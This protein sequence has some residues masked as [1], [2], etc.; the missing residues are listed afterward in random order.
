MPIKFRCPKC[1]KVYSVKKEYTGKKAKCSCG[2]IIVIPR[3]R[4]RKAV[5][6]I[7]DEVHSQPPFFLV[8]RI[9]WT[10]TLE[11]S[12]Q[13]AMASES[14]VIL[15]RLSVATRVGEHQQLI[16]TNR[17][18]IELTV[19]ARRWGW[20]GMWDSLS[21][22]GEIPAIG[23]ILE[24]LLENL[25]DPIDRLFKR[26]YRHAYRF[27]AVANESILSVENLPKKIEK[28]IT[29]SAIPYTKIV[30]PSVGVTIRRR[31][32]A[33]RFMKIRGT[34]LRFIPVGRLRSAVNGFF[35]AANYSLPNQLSV[36]KLVPVL[37]ALKPHLPSAEINLTETKGSVSVL[38]PANIGIAGKRGSV[39]AANIVTIVLAAI[40]LLISI[41]ALGD[42]E[43]FLLAAFFGLVTLETLAMR[44][45][46]EAI[47]VVIFLVISIAFIL[48]VSF[49][50]ALAHTI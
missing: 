8:Y 3:H 17:R 30:Q 16:F 42:E 11:T 33:F 22:V 38:W 48:V 1:N 25:K 43:L 26:S 7:V 12:I 29:A 39:R 40:T 24:I 10:S 47:V 14:E 15:A 23:L 4:M 37:R 28:R 20:W 27:N 13:Q 31:W 44:R 18:I 2:T 34:T 9:A 41:I 35:D 45:F 50:K 46:E 19:M 5:T 6:Y 49:M 21:L 32:F 36:D